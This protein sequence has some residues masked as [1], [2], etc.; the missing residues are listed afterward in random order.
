MRVPNR[1]YGGYTVDVEADGVVVRKGLDLE[2]LPLP[3]VK[4]AFES[5]RD[6]P[7]GVRL[8]ERLPEPVQREHVAVHADYG[9]QGWT[10]FEDGRL[11]YTGSVPPGD[12]VVTLL[13]V[14]LSEPDHIYGFL[15]QP[16][17]R[18]TSN[19]NAPSLRP[20]GVETDLLR[21]DGRFASDEPFERIRAAV[22]RAL[23]T[24]GDAD[25]QEVGSQPVAAPPPGGT[26][27]DSESA[28]SGGGPARCTSVTEPIREALPEPDNDWP[29]P[30]VRGG[31]GELDPPDEGTTDALLDQPVAPGSHFV[32]VETRDSYHGGGA[33]VVAQEL[34]N[35]FEIDGRQVSGDGRRDIVDVVVVTDQSPGRIVEALVDRPQVVDVFVSPVTAADEAPDPVIDDVVETF[36]ELAAEF[37][38]VDAAELEAELDETEFPG[39][40]GDEFTIADLVEGEID[41]ADVA[42]DA[43][44]DELHTLQEEIGR[45][46]D[47]V[48]ELEEELDSLDGEPADVRDDDGEPTVEPDADD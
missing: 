14:W 3:A 26:W 12:T 17:L 7:V 45:L 31:A 27:D 48:A 28:S 30:V 11:V 22:E 47:R 25:G 42:G 36:E 44:D 4:F 6:A 10:A 41:A 8:T 46:A 18:V 39:P 9:G 38:P 1:W 34:A 16:H 32:R 2:T 37:D 33:V 40:D 15:G 29:H 24:P 19:P 43:A 5:A 21:V 35:A 20:V 23:S 13:M